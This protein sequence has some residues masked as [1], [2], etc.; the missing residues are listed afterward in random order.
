MSRVVVQIVHGIFGHTGL[1]LVV[2]GQVIDSGEFGG[3]PEDNCESRDYSWVKS[4]LVLLAKRLGADAEIERVEVDGA[5][6]R[7]E[8]TRY[9]EAMGA[10]YTTSKP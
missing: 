9:F 2:D 5:T 3:E 7:E 8:R 1:R 6:E 10:P 4:M